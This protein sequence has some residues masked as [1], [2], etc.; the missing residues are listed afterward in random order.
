MQLGDPTQFA[1]YQAD[2][3]FAGYQFTQDPNSIFASLARQE[4]E[5]LNQIDE[6]TLSGNTFFSGRRLQNRNDLTDETGR[7]RLAGSTSFSDDLK[8]LAA[9]LGYAENDYNKALTDADQ[10]DIDAALER[11]RV[12][13][14]DWQAQQS[15]EPA[16]PGPAAP[17][18]PPQIPGMT[19][20]QVNQAIQQLSSPNVLSDMPGVGKGYQEK[21]GKDSKGHPGV[22]HIYPDGHKV[23]VRRR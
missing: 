15:E 12:A 18:P 6:G 4:T 1:K 9:A 3:N 5:G 8:G 10:M 14:E 22:W 7:Q 11:D 16:P 19:G 17:A 21:P 23:F 13:R 2:P 20:A